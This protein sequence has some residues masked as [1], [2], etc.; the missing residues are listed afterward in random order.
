MN[1]VTSDGVRLAYQEAGQP[2]W[3]AVVFVNGFGGYQAVWTAQIDYLVALKVRVITYDHR[4]SGASQHTTRG[5]TINRLAQ[6]LVE[7][8][9]QCQVTR[10]LLVGHSMGASVTWAALAQQQ[11][12]IRAILSVDQSPKMLNTPTW[13]YGFQQVTTATLANA[14]NQRPTT[15]ETLHGLVPIVAQPL[16]NAKA[17]HPFDKQANQPLLR[18]HYQQDWRS[19]L[20]A[21]TVPV[22]MIQAQQSPYYQSGY[23]EWL[24]QQNPH[25]TAVTLPDCGHDPMAEIPVGFNQTL[26]HFVL[27]TKG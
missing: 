15:S 13:P 24:H 8:C 21:S 26:R 27:K 3:P 4:N 11:L 5:L 12:A 9:H 17:A 25:V 18:D 10:P 19:T 16:V 7:L 2:T 22:T 23:G 20:V 6:D 1:F 14:L